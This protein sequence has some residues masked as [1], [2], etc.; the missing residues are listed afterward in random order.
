MLYTAE[1]VY[2]KASRYSAPSFGLIPDGGMDG[3]CRHSPVPLSEL[4][5]I[6]LGSVLGR[7]DNTR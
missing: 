2:I 5:G 4:A 1:D 7:I 6:Q 3:P